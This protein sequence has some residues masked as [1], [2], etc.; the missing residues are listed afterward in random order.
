MASI[1][2]GLATKLFK[3]GSH[4]CLPLGRRKVRDVATQ[5]GG[6]DQGT[7][8]WGPPNTIF[9]LG[10]GIGEDGLPPPPPGPPPMGGRGMHM[11]RP[12]WMVQ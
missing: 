10:D 2:Y 11:V 3:M 7:Q 4:C 1:C 12:H 5:C 6:D 9:D 8:T